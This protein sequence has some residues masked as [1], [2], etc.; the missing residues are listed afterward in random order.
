MGSTRLWTRVWHGGW[1]LAATVA[2]APAAAQQPEA[3]P[4]PSPDGP[5]GPTAEPAPPP[6]DDDPRDRARA[7]F[8][9][10]S[11]LVKEAKWAEALGAYERSWD[12]HHHAVTSYNIGAC[13]RSLGHYL[14]ARKF[15][16]R[17]LEEDAASGQTELSE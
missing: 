14:Q 8:Q 10:G 9:E 2:T 16:A 7:A 5:E 15:F 11:A 4:I 6:S 1:M 13:L 17:A 3:P 12:L